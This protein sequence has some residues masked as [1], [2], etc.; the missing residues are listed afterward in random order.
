MQESHQELER[1]KK[2]KSPKSESPEGIIQELERKI[3]ALK[4]DLSL[5]KNVIR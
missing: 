1:E 3:D 5:L 4:N 2:S